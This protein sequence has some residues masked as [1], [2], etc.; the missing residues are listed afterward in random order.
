MRTHIAVDLHRRAFGTGELDRARVAHLDIALPLERARHHRCHIAQ[1]GEPRRAGKQH[2]MQRR[3]IEP[4]LRRKYKT[5]AIEMP[6]RLDQRGRALGLAVDPRVE[7]PPL[8]APELL[9]AAERVGAFAE[10]ALELQ[11]EM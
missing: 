5:S 9:Q 8:V 3:L 11:I 10:L 4:R 1:G 2:G 7:E 6:A